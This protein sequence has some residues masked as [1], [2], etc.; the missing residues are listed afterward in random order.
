MFAAR[1]DEKERVQKELQHLVDQANAKIED[2]AKQK[3]KEIMTV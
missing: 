3:E 2:I 1:L